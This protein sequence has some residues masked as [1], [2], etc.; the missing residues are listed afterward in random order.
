MSTCVK[1]KRYLLFDGQ[2][3]QKH[4]D[5]SSNLRSSRSNGFG[6]K[7]LLRKSLSLKRRLESNWI[8]SN[9]Y[10]LDDRVRLMRIDEDDLESSFDD[11]YAYLVAS[12]EVAT[13]SYKIVDND[14]S[15][16]EYSNYV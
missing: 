4:L 6:V 9:K 13:F 16:V 7:R 11:E 5:D 2:K 12:P 14:F 8:K 3:R 15:N 1:E 10:C